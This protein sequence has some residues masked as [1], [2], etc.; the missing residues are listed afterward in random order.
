MSAPSDID[1][2]ALNVEPRKRRRPKLRNRPEPRPTLKSKQGATEKRLN[3][4]PLSPGVMLE[5]TEDGWLQTSPHNDLDLWE[6]QLHVALGTRSTSL[7]RV[8]IA[9]LK[10]LCRRD[11]DEDLQRWKWNET[12]LNAALALV[13]DV[14][15]RNATEAA[16]AA[17]MVAVHVLQMNLA[18]DA[19]NSGGMVMEKEAALVS[20]LARTFTMQLETLRSLRGGK[21]PTVRQSIK[22]TRETHY[23]K[24]EHL[25]D[26]RG[27]QELEEQP[28]EQHAEAITVRPALPSPNEGG[29]VVPL[30]RRNRKASV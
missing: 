16:L 11:W 30:P 1:P 8:F 9:Q 27:V 2:K 24:H 22:V 19:F 14:R 4:M 23:H 28:H 6:A 12:E 26:H 25:H 17:Q 15:P 13:A 5:P 7:V 18:M 10:N 3:A 21:R 20:K 29:E